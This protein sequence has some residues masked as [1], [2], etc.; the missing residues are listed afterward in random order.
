MADDDVDPIENDDVDPVDDD[1]G[2]KDWTPPKTKAEF[3]EM[4]RKSGNPEAA[5]WRRRATGKDPAW[6][7]N[8]PPAK[9]DKPSTKPDADKDAPVDAD[10]I[11]TAARAELKAEYEAES[12]RD[13]LKGEV[14]LALMAAGLNI[15]D[16]ILAQPAEARKAVAR[17]VNMLDLDGMVLE[18]G[19]VEGLDDEV[20]KLKREMPG[21]FKA[22]VKRPATKGG[23]A[24]P[25]KGGGAPD[26]SDPL[27]AMA[28]AWFSS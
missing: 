19:K 1:E 14:S 5:K 10:A 8:G 6:K 15:A 13:K 20:N 11:R 26:D 24:A 25:R 17:V 23:D 3:D 27:K 7:P 4:V 16:D 2:D 22:G 12:A 21:L 28:K 18:D 9:D